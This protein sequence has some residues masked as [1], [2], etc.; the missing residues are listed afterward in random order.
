MLAVVVRAS[1]WGPLTVAIG[2]HPPPEN[3]GG[4]DLP[5]LVAGWF[6]YQGSASSYVLS[7][8]LDTYTTA[9]PSAPV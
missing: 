9:P 6:R 1:H 5:R 2:L 7:L 3:T 4:W 8:H